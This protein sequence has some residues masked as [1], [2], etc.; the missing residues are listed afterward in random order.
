V[1]A[2]TR[3]SLILGVRR[4]TWAE[5]LWFYF[6]IMPWLVGFVLFTAGP[7]IAS[8]L[9]SFTRWELVRTPEWVGFE[10]WIRLAGDKL[11]WTSLRVTLSYTLL[12]VLPGLVVSFL[13]AY[14][15]NADVKGTPIFRTLFYLPSIVSGVAVAMLW[16]W[17]FNPRFG[18][19][20]YL[21]SL[22]GITGPDWLW[23]RQWVI[24]SFAIMSLWGAGGAMLIY[25]AGLQ[26]IPT[27]LYEAA[28]IDGA[29]GWRKVVNI[30]L[31]MIS[32]VIL[33]NLI[34]RMIGS[35]QVFTE[36]YVMTVGGPNNAS[37]FYVLYLYQN[38]FLYFRMGYASVLAW[39]L[40]VLIA[41]LT[42]LIFRFSRDA[43]YYQA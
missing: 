1:A 30:T 41:L 10:N 3:Q 33:F 18:L 40:F 4:T 25:L 43:V 22:V 21:L 15:L 8:V 16:L 5:D 35:M 7:M 24:P 42:A 23:S 6:F 36:A 26:S 37:L 20:N 29:S 31:P 9:I 28:E 11:F 19:I 34:M 39:I 13:L 32:P 38:A 17:I 12:S 2:E 14:I 27:E